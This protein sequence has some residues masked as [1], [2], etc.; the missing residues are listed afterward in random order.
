MIITIKQ[1]GGDKSFFPVL[2]KAVQFASVH[3]SVKA[4]KLIKEVEV[5]CVYLKGGYKGGGYFIFDGSRS[6]CKIKIDRR[7]ALKS[8]L[9]TVMHEMTHADQYFG[10]RLKFKRNRKGRKPYWRSFWDGV[11]YTGVKY[12]LLPWEIHA[13]NME[14]RMINKFILRYQVTV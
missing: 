2:K 6:K 13:N 14:E 9:S 12:E 11:E 8:K 10:G 3:M 4:R 7:S 1:V 5:W